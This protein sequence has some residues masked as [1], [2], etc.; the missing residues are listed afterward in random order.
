MMIRKPHRQ[1]P[2]LAV[3][4]TLLSLTFN[5]T[6]STS[7]QAAPASNSSTEQISGKKTNKQLANLDYAGTQTIDINDSHPTFSKKTLKTSKG[8]WQKY[9]QL[10]KLNRPTAANAMLQKSLMP[11]AK[12]E[13]LTVNPTGW[14][15]KKIKSGYLY[16]RSHLIGYQLTGQNNNPKNLIT[17]TRSLNSPEMLRFEDD[18]AYYLKSN[19]SGYIRYRVTPI[20]KSNEL[21]ARGV[22]MQAQSIGSNAVSF[23]VYIFNIEDGVT[24]NYNDGTS[25][26]SASEVATSSSSSSSTAAVQTPQAPQTTESASGDVTT[27]NQGEII[28]N[29]N[30]H[31]YHVPGQSGYHM[32]AAN[33]IYFNTEAEAQAAGYRK[34]LR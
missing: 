13:P 8:A 1:W 4:A 17:G 23:N 19:P 27:G 10:D 14:R 29:L 11:N 9:G 12:R 20:F 5:A 25:Q 33:A 32:N 15:N 26:I 18:I 6:A 30:S 24:L 2:L 31:I 3:V 34:S 28:G 16:N 21:L 22:H 7:T